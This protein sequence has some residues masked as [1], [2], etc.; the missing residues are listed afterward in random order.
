MDFLLLL[1]NG[2][3]NCVILIMTIKN[4]SPTYDSNYFIGLLLAFV[5]GYGT[6]ILRDLIKEKF[7]IKTSLIKFFGGL[8]LCYFAYLAKEDRFPDIKLEWFIIGAS[9]GSLYII[10]ALDK[11]FSLGI[12][13]AAQLLLTNLL[14]Y[15]DKS[16]T[17]EDKL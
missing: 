6:S 12:P 8:F 2:A 17:K 11:V 16:K 1:F 13:K 10:E 5:C 15:L 14:G 7:S 3:L 4:T 9:F